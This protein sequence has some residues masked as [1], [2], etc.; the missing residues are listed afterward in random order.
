MHITI[1]SSLYNCN[2]YIDNYIETLNQLIDLKNNNL[3]ITNIIDSNSDETN[4]KIDKFCENKNYIKLVKTEKADDKGL[5]NTWNTMCKSAKTELI[6]NLNCDD[7][8]HPNFLKLTIDKF[9]KYPDMDICIFPS[10]VSCNINDNFNSKL[11]TIYRKLPITD[12]YARCYINNKISKNVKGISWIELKKELQIDMYH[13][14][15]FYQSKLLPLNIFGCCPIFR[16]EMTE[17]YG[18]FDEKQYGPSADYELW[19]RLLSHNKKAILFT[20]IM[21]IY[22]I[23]DNSYSR[24]NNKKDSYDEAIIKKYNPYNDIDRIYTT[25]TIDHISITKSNKISTKKVQ[26]N[27]IYYFDQKWQYPVV[28]EKQVY[29]LL[30][31]ANNLPC[32]FF[33]FPFATL[34]DMYTHM[35]NDDLLQIIGD[36]S[37][38]DKKRNCF[39]VC[40][41]IRFRYLLPLMKKIGITH[42]FASHVSK[43]DY[44][45]EEKFKIKI[46]P[47]HLFAYNSINDFDINNKKEN[48]RLSFKGSYHPSHY[49]KSR[50]YLKKIDSKDILIEIKNKWHFED[51]VYKKQINEESIITDFCKDDEY[52]N[53]L[54]NS[55]F[56]LCP[57]GSGP[58]SIRLWE[59]L[60]VGSIPIILSDHLELYPQIEWHNYVIFWKE[61]NFDNLLKYL[62]NIPY[63]T[64]KLMQKNCIKLF[65]T[66]FSSNNFVKLIFE[67]FKNFEQKKILL[68]NNDYPAHYECIESLIC[69][70]EK[71]INSKTDYIYINLIKDNF[72]SF[73]NDNKY[74]FVSYIEKKYPQIS[75]LKPLRYDFFIEN[76]LSF[77]E[78]Y[79]NEKDHYYLSHRNFKKLEKYRNIILFKNFDCDILPFQNSFVMNRK[80]PIYLLSGDLKRKNIKLL[81]NILNMQCDKEYRLNILCQNNCGNL[82]IIKNLKNT[83][84]FN[85]CEFHL[86][87][88]YID[89]HKHI[90]GSYC[91]MLLLKEDGD[92]FDGIQFSG[93]LGICK[94]YNLYALMDTRLNKLYKLNN[95]FEFNSN[96][97][98]L[99]KFE[100][101]IEFFYKNLSS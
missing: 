85:R 69:K 22:Y 3:I 19:L 31:N 20:E 95:V 66:Y 87:K 42:V 12:D 6:C 5:Y 30:E 9:S 80:V 34:I 88:T 15:K 21:S 75:F 90:N 56:S 98:L 67:Y 18:G 8:L 55:T 65:N 83:K 92:Y 97:N 13:M 82:E 54:I 37:I 86:G 72:W 49:L 62:D 2:K 47:F 16:K 70:H 14:F 53:L 39:T 64:I 26:S 17:T 61:N 89:F 74:S 79:K 44:L 7:K 33:A 35:K 94:A 11:D 29:N 101:S 63:N 71:I 25:I 73:G 99:S 84:N 24:G 58:N 43:Y 51:I 1:I 45:Y 41:H 77:E 57:S 76:T 59:S 91:L 27:F 93:A 4:R 100:E 78:N 68:I 50:S 28:T 23:N 52:R 36:F 46:I 10:Y 40:Q 48:Y 96:D 38:I 60:S 81:E 32:D